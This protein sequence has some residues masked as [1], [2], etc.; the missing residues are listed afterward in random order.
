MIPH[1]P[2][3]KRQR[4]SY[5]TRQRMANRLYLQCQGLMRSGIRTYHLSEAK[6]R[7]VYH[8]SLADVCAQL[9]RGRFRQECSLS[10]YLYRVFHN[11]CIK[12]LRD[13]HAQKRVGD[14]VPLKDHHLLATDPLRRVEALDALA[15]LQQKSQELHPMLWQ[16]LE[17]RHLYGQNNQ[18]IARQLGFRTAAS[19]A[20]TKWRYF[21]QLQQFYHHT[22]Y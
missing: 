7:D 6:S 15:L 21:Q 4:M 10:S 20:S 13:M 11:R 5:I 1:S 17:A 16:I 19:V 22:I 3:Q 2:I 14:S 12:A 18:E 8:D 9:N